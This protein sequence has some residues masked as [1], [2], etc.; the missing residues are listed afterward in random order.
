MSTRAR[1]ISLTCVSATLAL[2]VS[3]CGGG[4][5]TKS[6]SATPTLTT[7]TPTPTLTT[8]SAT[9]APAPVNPLTG[10]SPSNNPVVAVKIDDTGNGRPQVNIDKADLVYVEQVE[11]GLTRLIGVF[12]TQ[13]PSVEAVRSVRANDPELLAQFGPIAFAASGGAP[14]PLSVLDQSP[15]KSSIN[16]RG[17]PG[18]SRDG[19]RP[20]P[21]NL[22]ANLAQIGSALHGP[23]AK[24]IGLTFAALSAGQLQ[25]VAA[26]TSVRTVV[27]AT[28]VQFDWNSQLHKYV[29]LIGGVQQ[30]AADGAPIATPNVI[31]QFCSV[32]P[33]PQDV[34]V[35]GNVAQFTHSVGTGRAVLFRDGHQ[36]EG[37]W[38]RSA[39]NRGTAFLSRLGKPLPLAPGGAWILLVATGAPLSS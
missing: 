27:G 38:S 10:G 1:A 33:Y 26:G 37:T 28:A 13:L 20:A 21:Y 3:A 31:V 36:F 9:P 7:A 30:S 15:L 8:S 25:S 32:T 14:N 17:G 29:R 18:F 4:H 12:D 24:S 39:A 2:A 5:S 22:V 35:V 34:D 19:N 16:D 6:A 23:R 11:G